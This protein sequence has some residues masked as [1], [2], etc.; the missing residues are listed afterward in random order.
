[1]FD[2][3]Q[4]ET[5]DTAKYHVKDAKGRL[6]YQQD[7]SPL[8]ITAHGPGTKRAAQAKFAYD[9]KRSERALGKIGGKSDEMTEEQDRRERAEYLGQ[10]VDSLDGFN[11]E[12][13]ATGLFKNP[14]LRYLA[15]DFQNWWNDA[16][17]F[18]SSSAND[19]SSS[20]DTQPG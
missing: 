19:L 5:Q 17:N 16:G 3:S 8:T 18:N 7:G 12:G 20:S 9:A 6:Q 15:E 14:K 13:G 10:L 4:L 2:I 11:H 1:M